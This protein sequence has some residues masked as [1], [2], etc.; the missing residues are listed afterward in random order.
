MSGVRICRYLLSDVSRCTNL[1]LPGT[2]LALCEQHAPGEAWAQ[3]LADALDAVAHEFEK[4]PIPG[5]P[6]WCERPI[7]PGDD[8]LV[9]GEFPDHPVHRTPAR[10]RAELE[11]Q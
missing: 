10:V 3:A 11:T 1:A 6:A 9:C 2:D 7:E 4:S 5:Y 8:P